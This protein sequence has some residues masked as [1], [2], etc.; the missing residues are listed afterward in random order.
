MVVSD[1][2]VEQFRM[3]MFELPWFLNKRFTAN[4]KELGQVG[5]SVVI[6]QSWLPALSG[7]HQRVKFRSTYLLP[8]QGIGGVIK[9]QA[10]S[11]FAVETIEA[12]CKLVDDQ[13]PS[14]RRVAGIIHDVVPGENN[15]PALPG[16]TRV[17]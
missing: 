17:T 15:L 13:V 14:V 11:H 1:E 16:F 12:M 2:K 9:R 8:S 10:A 4:G 7:G 5:R 3:P 6:E